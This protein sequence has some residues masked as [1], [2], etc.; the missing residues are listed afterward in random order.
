[1][2]EDWENSDIK[3]PHCAHFPCRARDCIEI[4]CNEGCIDDFDDD[5]LWFSP[6]DFHLCGECRGTG[7]VMWCPSCGNDPRY[8]SRRMRHRRLQISRRLDRRLH[9][10]RLWRNG[11]VYHRWEQR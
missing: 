10:G 6:G 11:E 7:V 2:S 3:C 8:P 1:M 5:P 4:G 9:A